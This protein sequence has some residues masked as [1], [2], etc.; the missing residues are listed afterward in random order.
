MHKYLRS[1]GQYDGTSGFQVD[2]ITDPVQIEG[3][4]E[5]RQSGFGELRAIKYSA[6]IADFVTKL[7]GISCQTP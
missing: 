7:V 3:L 6:D 1:L 5:T 4:M 2:D